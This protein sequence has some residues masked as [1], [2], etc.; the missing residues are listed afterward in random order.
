MYKAIKNKKST[1]KYIDW[2]KRFIEQY[3]NN[4]DFLKYCESAIWKVIS[5]TTITKETIIRAIVIN[6]E[7]MHNSFVV[8]EIITTD[9]FATEALECYRDLSKYRIITV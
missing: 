5:M 3:G 8:D 6:I 7:N 1:Q 2:L 4:K 9:K